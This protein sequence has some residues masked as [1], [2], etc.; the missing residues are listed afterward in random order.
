[1]QAAEMRQLGFLWALEIFN[2]TFLLLNFYYLTIIVT[3][4]PRKY[5]SDSSARQVGRS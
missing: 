4:L 1:M 5:F 2:A 3:P